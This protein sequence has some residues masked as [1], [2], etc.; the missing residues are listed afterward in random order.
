MKFSVRKKLIFGNATLLLSLI[1]VAINGY[2][3]FIEVIKSKETLGI[4]TDIVIE[5]NTIYRFIT[6]ARLIQDEYLQNKS[7]I[8]AQRVL[9][10]INYL[11]RHAKKYVISVNQ[12]EILELIDAANMIVK[13]S[14][15]YLEISKKLTESISNRGIGN[16]SGLSGDLSKTLNIL[17]GHL[18]KSNF[19]TIKLLYFEYQNNFLKNDAKASEKKLLYQLQ[20]YLDFYQDENATNELLDQFYQNKHKVTARY[21][22]QF[23]FTLNKLIKEDNKIRDLIPLMKE[24]A[25][26]INLLVNDNVI[27][28]QKELEKQS[29]LSNSLSNRQKTSLIL[30]SFGAILIGI[31]SLFLFGSEPLGMS[32]LIQ[33]QAAILQAVSDGLIVV[34]RSANIKMINHKGKEIL[35][36]TDE[37]IGQN[38]QEII[39]NSTL[40]DVMQTGVP[41][42]NQEMRSGKATILVTRI[43]IIL[44]NSIIGC[45]A[46]IKAKG[47]LSKLAGQLTQINAYI[48]AL[49]AN[50]HEFKNKLQTIQ[51]LIQ[52][53]QTEEV[54]NYIQSI[55]LSHQQRI[56]LY[57]DKIK[58]PAISAIL[59]GKYNRT[60]ELGISLFLNKQSNL[61]VLPGYLDQNGLVSVIGNLI[62]NAIDAVLKQPANKRKIWITIR[63]FEKSIYISVKDTGPGIP[64][65]ISSKIF[66]RGFSTKHGHATDN[67]DEL[68]NKKEQGRGMG[69]YITQ[70]HVYSMG[71]NIQFK[72][73]Y[74]TTFEII[75]P[76]TS[77]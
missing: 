53:N 15:E 55:Q 66:E 54:L 12:T 35:G 73:N 62:D 45:I 24:K 3:S 70:N 63:E 25:G 67:P 69:L 13:S 60:N 1:V 39:P 65:D 40:L 36:V 18:S 41:E 8:H 14:T 43:P 57:V 9:N 59:L 75:I 47:E 28:V 51:G 23:M 46:C 42:Y 2:F 71:G 19:L 56:S 4:Y 33:E 74:G 52:L 27:A 72:T 77:I 20:E 11:Q 68:Q 5:S 61:E 17:I 48:D 76:T 49:R 44:N 32:K 26:L 38:I 37:C 16:K 50:N 30:I 31:I 22:K 29:R 34:D 21:L 7:S 64:E 10:K 58:D 6:E